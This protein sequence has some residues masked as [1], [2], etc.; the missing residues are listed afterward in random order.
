MKKFLLLPI[1]SV[2]TLQGMEVVPV[3]SADNVRLLTNNRHLYVEDENA[4]YRVKEHDMNK[5]LRDVLKHKALAKFKEAGYIRATKQSDG[6][7]ALAAKIRGE[8]GTGPITA[9]CVGTAVK[10]ICW[11]GVMVGGSFIYKASEKL[12]RNKSLQTSATVVGVNGAVAMAGGWTA[13]AANI[14]VIGNSAAAATLAL[15]WPLP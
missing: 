6:T 15:P 14:E 11:M 8:G 7:Y 3:S 5:E 13:V 12:E 4:A 9:W 1:L 2:L 10:G